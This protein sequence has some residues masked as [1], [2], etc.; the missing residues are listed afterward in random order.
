VIRIKR[1][2]VDWLV[3]PGIAVCLVFFFGSL[4]LGLVDLALLNMLSMESLLFD[5]F[6]SPGAFIFG[7]LCAAFSMNI[8]SF[9]KPDVQ[10]R[11]LR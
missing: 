6:G 9:L 3:H 4:A 2:F 7:Y 11:F 10:D 1:L 8:D 5:Q